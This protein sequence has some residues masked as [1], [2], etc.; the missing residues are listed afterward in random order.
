MP[1]S[2]P[3]D[4][5]GKRKTADAG[6]GWGADTGFGSGG[7]LWRAKINVAPESA[8]SPKFGFY[9]TYIV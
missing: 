1:G 3:V 4:W 2:E 9:M 7:L 6:R 8:S 5:V